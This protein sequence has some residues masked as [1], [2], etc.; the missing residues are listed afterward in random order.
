M[1][2][3]DPIEH[4]PFTIPAKPKAPIT[5]VS[6]EEA[7]ALLSAQARRTDLKPA[8]YVK[9]LAHLARLQDWHRAAERE[10]ARKPDPLAARIVAEERRRKAAASK[11]EAPITE[12]K[13]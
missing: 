11:P 13:V 7:I 6:R 10:A 5:P 2:K 8:E 3:S 9:V 1:K 12:T 4:R